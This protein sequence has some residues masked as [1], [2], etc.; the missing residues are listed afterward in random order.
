MRKA[1]NFIILS[2]LGMLL[3]NVALI[4]AAIV[5]EQYGS[6]TLFPGE[7]YILNIPFFGPSKAPIVCGKAQ[8]LAGTALRDVNVSAYYDDQLVTK[9]TT[10]TKG[11]YCLTL[12]EL[13]ASRKYDIFIEYNN[14]TTENLTLGSND[15]SLD[16]LNNQIYSKSTTQFIT[17]QGQISNHDAEIESGRFEI[18]I[19][20]K[21]NGTW[22][23]VTDYEKYFIDLPSREILE[24]PNEELNITWQIPPEA[25][26]GQYKWYLKSSFNAKE[27]TKD[28]FF[29][30]T[31]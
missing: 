13:T 3:I 9:N 29:N 10:N 24:L 19:R 23:D 1:R 27:R 7:H 14:E 16:F 26:T 6:V 12:P 20:H 4:S 11:E 31:E 5:L 28:V 17:L 30:I 22:G 15:Y 8:T 25:E 21:N 18:K 2:V